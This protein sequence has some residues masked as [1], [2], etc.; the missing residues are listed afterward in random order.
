MA[1]ARTTTFLYPDNNAAASVVR[2]EYL[3]SAP[4]NS[5]LRDRVDGGWYQSK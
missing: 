3:A 5:L 1:I 4:G 2:L